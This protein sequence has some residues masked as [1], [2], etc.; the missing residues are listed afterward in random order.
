MAGVE[1]PIRLESIRTF[2]AS[3]AGAP[4]YLLPAELNFLDQM[5]AAI[6][7]WVAARWPVD[8]GTSRDAWQY[9]T[10]G[11]KEEISVTVYNDVDYVEW[12]HYAGTPEEPRLWEQLQDEI[13]GALADALTR[14]RRLIIA[15][16]ADLRAWYAAK[17]GVP[18]HVIPPRGLLDY[19]RAHQRAA[20]R[21]A[22]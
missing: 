3:Q 1:I 22:A 2:L 6:R 5:G 12:V 9:S 20:V 4:R 19:A 7:D 18:L 8:T 10:I 13:P 17:T 11:T 21:M 16:Q 14:F 15:T